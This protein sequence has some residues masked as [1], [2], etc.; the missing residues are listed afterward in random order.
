[1][2]RTGPQKVGRHEGQRASRLLHTVIV[3]LT[4]PRRSAVSMTVS[5]PASQHSAVTP[6]S[7]VRALPKSARCSTSSASSSRFSGLMSRCITRLRCTAPHARRSSI[8]WLAGWR[9]VGLQRA[10]GSPRR[11]AAGRSSASTPRPGAGPAA[12][13]ARARE[14]ERHGAAGERAASKGARAGAAAVLTSSSSA[15]RART[16]PSLHGARPA[17]SAIPSSD[18]RARLGAR[19]ATCRGARWRS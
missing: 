11:T 3:P 19:W 14:R 9:R 2:R 8:S 10:Y 6:T 13:C 4:A 1:M 18:G 7:H 16:A 12:G 5:Q 15:P 17:Q